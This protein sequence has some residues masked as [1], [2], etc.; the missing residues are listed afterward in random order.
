MD[1]YAVYQNVGRSRAVL[2]RLSCAYYKLHGGEHVKNQ[3]AWKDFPAQADIKHAAAWMVSRQLRTTSLC[4]RC[5][6]PR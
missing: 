3:G 2:H 4:S 5:L 1:D 6:S